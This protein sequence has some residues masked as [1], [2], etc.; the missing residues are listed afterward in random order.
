MI[1]SP[2]LKQATFL[3]R[4]KRFLADIE[5]ANGEIITIYCPNTGAMTNCMVE[6]SP[7]WYSS[8]DNAKRKYKHTLE[9]VTASTG[10]LACIHAAKANDL[11]REA[12]EQGSI[13]ELLGY[14]SLEAEVKYGTENSRIDFLLSDSLESGAVRSLPQKANCYVEVKSVTLGLEGGQGLFPDAVSARGT[15]HLREL[16]AMVKNQYRA[17]IIFCVQHEGI[18]YFSAAKEIDPLYSHTL[19]E[20]IDIGVEVLVYKAKISSKEIVLVESIPCHL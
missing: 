2:S 20:A 16:I 17:V 4:Y 19:K 5:L 13:K 7:C 10:H 18:E 9:L 3:R 1:F 12:I 11:V 14:Q 15:K 6:G 8:S